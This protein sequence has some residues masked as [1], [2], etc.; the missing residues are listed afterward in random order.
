M[1]TCQN[2]GVEV[3]DEAKFCQNCG[4]DINEQKATNENETKFCSNCGFELDKNIKFCPECGKATD[5]KPITKDNVSVTTVNKDPILAAILSFFIVGLGQ[6]YIG[7]TKKGIILFLLAFISAI[8]IIFIIGWFL[9]VVIYIYAK[10]DAYNSA[11]KINAG[12]TVEDTLDFNN[13]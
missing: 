7:L 9:W 12:E 6:I 5:N 8:L 11:N 1:V 2:C 10:D 3:K 4:A 13:L